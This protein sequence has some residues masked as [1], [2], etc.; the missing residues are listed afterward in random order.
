[1]KRTLAI[2]FAVI[3]LC[4]FAP[5]GCDTL[6]AREQASS[7]SISI[8]PSSINVKTGEN[9][10]VNVS[11]D[12]NGAEIMGLEY[13][14]LFDTTLVTASSVTPGDFFDGF[15]TMSFG[16][17]INNSLGLI[18]Y[19]EA[20]FDEGCVTT[21]GTVTSIAFQTTGAPGRAGL[22][23]QTATLSNTTGYK[24]PVTISNSTLEIETPPYPFL[25]CGYA[26]YDDGTD[27][28]NPTVAITNL[29]TSES[30]S[31]ETSASSHYYQLSL[32]HGQD[33]Y[34]GDIL[35]F[36]V[37]G[38]YGSEPNVTEHTTTQEEV[39]NGGLFNFNITLENESVSFDTG[40]SDDPY[41][42]ISGVH[43]G[44]IKPDR[45]IEANTIYTYSCPGT[46]GHIEYAR[47]WGDDVDAVATWAGYEGDWHNLTF[48]T[49]FVLNPGSAYNYTIRT[50]S[51]PQIIH[52]PPAEAQHNVT[53]GAITCDEFR[54]AN[55]LMHEGWIPAFRLWKEEG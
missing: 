26:F 45:P 34:A 55:G 30:W 25:I 43:N 39:N 5:I 14:I 32:T 7:A 12:P 35:Q 21:Q 16:E 51:Y 33:I 19:A 6:A 28:K 54:D 9:F 8:E 24:I 50:D 40:A 31:A 23:F 18:D 11:L 49:M 1:M 53:G 38:P 47:L 37:T 13:I 29:N 44:T 52:V 22:L 27:C 3:V 41:P 10:T 4:S 46:G 17:G 36:N 42:S 15:T 48:N 2:V 20:I